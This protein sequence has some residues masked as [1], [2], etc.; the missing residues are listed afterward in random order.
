MTETWL[1]DLGPYAIVVIFA[2]YIV[3][4]DAGI[5]KGRGND[6][7]KSEIPKPIRD[8]IETLNGSV[9]RIKTI[10]NICYDLKNKTD[11]LYKWHDQ[12]DSDGAFAWYVRKSLET[13]ID[14]LASNIERQTN[15]SNTNTQVLSG[16]VGKIE[17]MDNDIKAIKRNVA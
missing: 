9:T 17:N 16:L 15:S 3:L 10:E 11:D 13:S 2:L 6:R 8:H 4:K 12:R 14:K 1:K 5:I 7:R